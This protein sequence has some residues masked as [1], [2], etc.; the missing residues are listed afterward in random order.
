MT[1]KTI[2]E[3]A[4]VSTTTVHRVL[5]GKGDVSPG[6]VKLI[7]DIIKKS[8]SVKM[9]E[10]QLSGKDKPQD[11]I[12]KTKCIGLL[13][14]GRPVELL[15]VPLFVRL[16]TEIEIA[17]A[18]R[19]LMMT[20]MH[21]PE[22]DKLHP[23]IN[24]ERLDGIFVLGQVSSNVLQSKLRDIHSVGLLGSGH[25]LENWAD[26]V[27]SDFITRGQMAL[28]YLRERGHRRVAFLNPIR[29]Q[30]AYRQVGFSFC[31]TAEQEGMQVKMLETENPNHAGIWKTFEGRPAIEELVDKLMQIPVEQRPTGLHVV[32]DEICM[33]VYKSL[34]KRGV[35]PGKD[36]DI[37]SCGNHE[38]FLTQMQPR[39]ATMDLNVAE[40]A[41]CGIDRLVF[42]IKNPEALLGVTVTVPPKLISAETR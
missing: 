14:V 18:G 10:R 40:I 29:Q 1:L 22:A 12:F 27:T 16:M 6:T 31:L 41:Q 28:R 11:E 13:L 32:N 30:S 9:K 26:R 37:I 20:V 15:K 7:K 5:K 39:P 17:L 2:A 34:I 25:Y 33:S 24:S 35:E 42:R 8:G 21:M 4:G 38:E 19:G 36:I 23:M 3:Q